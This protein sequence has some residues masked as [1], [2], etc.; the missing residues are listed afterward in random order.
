MKNLNSVLCCPKMGFLGMT[1]LP[2]EGK[3]EDFVIVLHSWFFGHL[4]RNYKD[5]CGDA[6]QTLIVKGTH[7]LSGVRCDP[8]PGGCRRVNV[9]C[10]NHH[11]EGGAAQQTTQTHRAASLNKE[12]QVGDLVCPG[13]CCLHPSPPNLDST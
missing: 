12:L 10:S 6:S 13:T 3:A 7:D 1:E 5:P 8:A 4:A 11:T 2:A 9:W